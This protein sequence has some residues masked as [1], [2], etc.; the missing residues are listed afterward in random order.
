[1]LAELDTQPN[2]RA[3]LG[4]ALAPGGRPSH[5]YLVHG[6]GGAGKRVVARALAAE[7]LGEGSPDRQSARSRVQSGSHPD[8]TWVSPSGAHEILV[9][10]IDLPV[11][12]AA[13]KTPFE[14]SRR[15]FVIESVD[16]LSDEAGNRML[17]TLEEPAP[18]VH[19]ILITDRL[20]QVLPTIRSRCQLVR[21]DAPAAEQVAAE[22]AATGVEPLAALACARLGLG[23]AAVS[24]ELASGQGAEL[25]SAA[26]RYARAALAG[27]S[28]EL[29]PWQG[30]L[31]A[32]RARGETLC[33]EIEQL[34]AADLDLYPRREKKR[35]ETEW[36]DRIRRARR[37]TE[38]AELDRALQLVS[39]WF[40]DLA[41]LAWGAGDLVRH[42][43]R[44]E[45]LAADADAGADA[46]GLDAAGV[47]VAGADAGAAR[48]A[49][50]LYE[51]IELVE[52]TRIRFALNVSE[53]LACEALAYR[54]ERTLGS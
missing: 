44:A 5:A 52:N 21:F 51:A 41:A 3:L 28:A 22:L 20:A 47:D 40:S 43:D 19:L 10:D 12:A 9:S 38:T 8:L 35:V 32:V 11:V 6:P 16:E 14:S 50:R 26:E 33:A 1:M 18:F 48:R 30:L 29:E 27:E 23:D 45:Q 36:T 54:L 17:K 15:V 25:R 49:A 13:S 2:A 39:L 42:V 34:K 37:R 4:P 7:L 46:A 24:R 53:D 31:E